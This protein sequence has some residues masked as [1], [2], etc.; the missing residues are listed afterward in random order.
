MRA[1]RRVEAG[2]A[3][4]DRGTFPRRLALAGVLGRGNTIRAADSIA[5]GQ[6]P[7][8]TDAICG[9]TAI[10]RWGRAPAGRC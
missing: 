3:A 2:L 8:R 9:A 6:V 7:G 5:P 10:F 4:C 1:G